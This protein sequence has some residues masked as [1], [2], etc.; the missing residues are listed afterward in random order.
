MDI[1]EIYNETIGSD[2]NGVAKSFVSLSYKTFNENTNE[3]FVKNEH[4][5]HKPV[6]NI[7]SAEGITQILLQFPAA[8]DSD[9]R[10]A[11][12]IT[13]KYLSDIS[14][15]NYNEIDIPVLVL[16]IIPVSLNGQYYI[17]ATTPLFQFVCS[18]SP[19]SPVNSICFIFKDEDVVFY[20]TDEISMDQIQG[21]IEREMNERERMEAVA[22]RKNAE[23]EAFLEKRDKAFQEMRRF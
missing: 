1:N 17:T 5:M 19:L 12:N 7:T 18:D 3:I 2:E 21:E 23:R 22:E 20:E 9:M 6:V 16:N 4:S 14:D 10:I 15:T 11:W 13:Q 8:V